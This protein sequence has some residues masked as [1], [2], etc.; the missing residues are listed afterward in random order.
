[1]AQ[2]LRQSRSYRQAA[3]TYERILS[4]FPHS[5]EATISLVALGQLRLSVLRQPG[6][7]LALFEEYLERAPNGDLAATAI[8]C[9]VRALASAGRHKEVIKGVEKYLKVYP[10]GATAAEM[11]RRRGEALAALGDCVGASREFRLVITRWGKS[12][13][14]QRAREG[15]DICAKTK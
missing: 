4:D 14:A 7:A 5:S 13:E 6:M 9:R 2:E 10:R 8:S 11:Y 15:L 12:S 1:L 3:E